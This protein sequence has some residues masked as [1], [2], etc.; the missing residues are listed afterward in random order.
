M[1][2]TL[3]ALL[4]FA[5][6]LTSAHAATHRAKKTLKEK[7]M[8]AYL[9][10]FFNDPTH[11]LFMAISYDGYTFTAVNNGEPIIS[12]DSIADQRGIRDPHIYR[13]PNGSF[14]I[15]M[16]DLHV[17]GKERGLRTTQWERPDQYGWG[18]NRGLVLMKSDDLIHWTHHEVRIDQLFPKRFGEIGCAWAPETIWDP[19]AKRLMVYFTIREKAGD[20]TKL[21]YSYANDDF[22][23][24]E[25]EPQLLFEY[26]DEKIQVLDADIC[27]MPDGRYFMTYVSQ[28][29][30][31]GIKYM[32]SKDIHHY[33]DYHAEQI[34]A[35]SRGCEAPNMW[36]RIGEKKWVLM[37]D[38]YSVSPHNFGFV[39]TSDFKTFKPLGRFNEGVMKATN[40]V[41]PKHGSVI[42]I[43]KAEAQRLENYWKEQQAKPR[44]IRSGELWPDVSGAHINAHGG[45][46]LDH[47]GTYYWFGEHKSDSTSSAMVGV[48][49]YS[50]TDLTHW[51]N[52][53]VALA[54]TDKAGDDIERGCILERPK[55]VYNAKTG[56]FVMWFHLELKGQG[57]GA[58]RYGVAISDRPEGPY[59]FLYSSRSDAGKYPVEMGK[60]ERAVLDTL[61]A[62]RYKEWW[63]PAWYDA[64]GKG[65]FVKRDL[66]SG[67]MARDM[68]VYVDDDGK[69]YHVFSSE[70]NMT[71]HI[72]E[73]TDDYTAHSGRYTRVAAGGQNEAPALFKKD[74]TYWMITSGCT[75]WAPNEARM[76]SAPSIWGPWTQHP[77]PCVGPN[78]G[79]TFGGQSTYVLQKD[80]KYIFM[81]D[82]W[83]PNH[84][85][86]ARYIW[87]PITFE[88]GKPVV[89]WQDSWSPGE[90]F[91]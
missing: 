81:A 21:Y 9:F 57:Y 39:E 51:T 36:K 52:R 64:V 19:K 7:D 22:T 40:F 27:P 67:Q 66:G 73:L 46:I 1:H 44:T 4:F 61:N 25:T 91:K 30:P 3:G 75:G 53:G 86:D 76:F 84:P 79:K 10:T 90:L 49:C 31:G 23:T 15:A 2:K 54:V 16:T 71:L 42:H 6:A 50:S 14:Y 77:N 37:Y 87:L 47:N 60:A 26:P 89:R 62:D 5:L 65:L 85:S 43:T 17:F 70:D 72:A 32:I 48:M 20:R 24:L 56:K 74:G 41:S 28:E 13:A 82:I 12:G 55:V 29:N 78:A 69:A 45:G 58:A 83:R 80:G 11:S 34:D 8:G 68:T 59:R 18:N 33:D 88:G 35:E 63:T 38:I